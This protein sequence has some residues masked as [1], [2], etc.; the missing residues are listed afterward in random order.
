MNEFMTLI[1]V[2]MS[3]N[4]NNNNKKKK[5]FILKMNLKEKFILI[6][7]VSQLFLIETE[8]R[9][10]SNTKYKPKITRLNGPRRMSNDIYR[11]LIST[12]TEELRSK[13][14]GEINKQMRQLKIEPES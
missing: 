14:L 8:S 9:A 1:F 7:L 2:P 12:N 3:H 4:I 5:G 13:I 6:L 11:K 10:N